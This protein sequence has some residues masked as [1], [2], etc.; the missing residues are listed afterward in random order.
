MISVDGLV[1]GH[2]Q[3]SLDERQIEIQKERSVKKQEAAFPALGIAGEFV[4]SECEVRVSSDVNRFFQKFSQR[5]RMGLHD[6]AIGQRDARG[7]AAFID[8]ED[9][10]IIQA[11]WALQNRSATAAPAVNG[12]VQRFAR[13]L[14]DFGADLV[15]VADDYKMPRWFPEA[16]DFLIETFLAQVKQGF[17]TGQ[18]L[19]RSAKR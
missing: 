2:E 15:R 12:N 5:S 6:E 18:I 11:T 10:R 7:R 8:A 3:G 1:R 17:V 13:C 16:Q 14:V 19:C 9:Q 4:V